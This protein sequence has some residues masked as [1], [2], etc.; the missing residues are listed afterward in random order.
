[1]NSPTKFVDRS[2]LRRHLPKNSHKVAMPQIAAHATQKGI[3]Q[4]R[5]NAGPVAGGGV[6]AAGPAVGQVD[7]HL[8][9]RPDDVVRLSARYIADHADAAGLM[10]HLGIVESLARGWGAD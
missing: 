9:S 3:R 1:M 10:L 6:T 8:Q 4:L 7:R 5:Q 2:A